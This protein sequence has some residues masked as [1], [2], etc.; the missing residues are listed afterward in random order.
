MTQLLFGESPMYFDMH[1]DLHV[2]PKVKET[3]AP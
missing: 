2:N 1:T 3:V